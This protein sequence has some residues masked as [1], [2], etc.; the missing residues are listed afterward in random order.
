ME[1]S[2]IDELENEKVKCVE[3][4]RSFEKYTHSLACEI[5]SNCRSIEYLQ[6]TN[7]KLESNFN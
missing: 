3:L 4:E 6:E 1:K 5:S 7:I 2:K